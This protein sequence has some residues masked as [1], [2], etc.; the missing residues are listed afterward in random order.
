[1]GAIP[2]RPGP[3]L[4]PSVPYRIGP[5]RAETDFL[6]TSETA[7]VALQLSQVNAAE[8]D[9]NIRFYVPK[10]FVGH[11]PKRWAVLSKMALQ[12]SVWRSCRFS[13]GFKHL[14]RRTP[15]RTVLDYHRNPWSGA[16]FGRT[17]PRTILVRPLRCAYSGGNKPW[18]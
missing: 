17:L 7:E 6:A 2:A 10:S 4:L 8:T 1:M 13:A 12:A 14:L 9:C 3:I 18:S 5:G 16:S 11:T 15:F